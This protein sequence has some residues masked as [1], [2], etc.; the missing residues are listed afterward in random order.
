MQTIALS[1]PFALGGILKIVY[2]VLLWKTFKDLKPP[3]GD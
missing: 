3:E 1:A 2:D